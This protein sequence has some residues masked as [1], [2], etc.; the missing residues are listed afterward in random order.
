MDEVKVSCGSLDSV[1]ERRVRLME[2]GQCGEEGT[3]L[4]VPGI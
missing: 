4:G 3:E 2:V 1:G